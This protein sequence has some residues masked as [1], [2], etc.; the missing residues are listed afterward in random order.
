MPKINFNVFSVCI[1]FVR[2]GGIFM[3]FAVTLLYVIV[4]AR[5]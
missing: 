2:F 3:N 5:F 4:R 1:L